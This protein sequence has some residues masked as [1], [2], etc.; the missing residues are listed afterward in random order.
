MKSAPQLFEQFL[1]TT[2][3]FP[4]DKDYFNF[5]YPRYKLMIELIDS[6]SKKL[7]RKS[8]KL[9]DLGSAY[10]H[11]SCLCS[12]RGIDVCALDLGKFVNQPFLQERA[13]KYHIDLRES[14]FS[15]EKIPFNKNTFDIVLLLET[16]EHF[17]FDPTPLLKDVYNVLKDDGYFVITVPNFFRLGNKL[18]MLFNRQILPFVKTPLGEGHCHEYGA[19]ELKELLIQTGFKKVDIFYFDYSISGN[20]LFTKLIKKFFCFFC[21]SLSGNLLAIAQKK[22]TGLIKYK[23]KI[24]ALKKSEKGVE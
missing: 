11:L 10:L 22:Q 18:R 16:L 21:P 1:N 23:E 19:S 6:L 9:L 4:E 15:K 3:L 14:D 13:K 5:H 20:S 2:P 24:E 12:L 8:I 7:N 17:Y